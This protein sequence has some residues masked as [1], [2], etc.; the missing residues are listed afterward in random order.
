MSISI[1]KNSDKKNKKIGEILAEGEEILRKSGRSRADEESLILLSYL[2][3]KERFDLLL[4]RFL[5]VSPG[6]KKRYYDWIEERAKGIPLQYITGFQNFMGMEF[7][8]RKSI[9]IPRPETEILVEEIIK[10]IESMPDRTKLYFLDIGTGSGVIPISICYYFQNTS[11]DIHFYASD[12]SNKAIK[13][14]QENAKRFSCETKVTFLYGDFFETQSLNSSLCFDG[15]ISNPPYISKSEFSNLPEEVYHYEPKKAL[16][17]GIKGLDYYQKIMKQSSK[18]LKKRNSFLALEIG[19]KQKEAVSRM[20]KNAGNFQDKIL[21]F[22]DYYQ[23]DRVI[24][25]LT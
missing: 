12:I 14:A 5:N 13:L 1:I 15:I 7:K 23:N 3:K 9:F 11:K 4:N 19:H 2:L 20:I 17:G 18:Y 21:V 6:D 10:L 25:A 8:L 16:F 24:V 22:R